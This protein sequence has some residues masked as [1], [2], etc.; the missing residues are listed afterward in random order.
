MSSDVLANFSC[1]DEL[2]QVIYQSFY[3][4]V[5]LS[6]VSGDRWTVHLGLSG[7]EGRWWRGNWG[8]ADILQVVV[9]VYSSAL[10]QEMPAI[11]DDI[12]V[13]E[14]RVGFKIFG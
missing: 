8:E 4:F 10:P 12:Y 3:R 7:P 6:N 14:F 13:T 2:T 11:A 1:L 9:R 5:V